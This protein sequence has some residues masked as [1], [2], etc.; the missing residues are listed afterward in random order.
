M[1]DTTPEAVLTPSAPTAV[2]PK[3]AVPAANATGVAAKKANVGYNVQTAV[4][5]SSD[6][7]IPVWLAALTGVFT[8]GAAMVLWQ[9][10][11]RARNSEG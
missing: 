7:G 6:T 1:A 9:G 5:R 4:G 8:A 3:A 2:V 10:G 11:R